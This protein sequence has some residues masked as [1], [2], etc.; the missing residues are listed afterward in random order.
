[1]LARIMLCG[2]GIGHYSPGATS[3]TLPL[4]PC[5]WSRR[6]ATRPS[7]LAWARPGRFHDWPATSRFTDDKCP[8]GKDLR[9]NLLTLG[10]G[11]LGV[12]RHVVR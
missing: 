9:A 10:L 8:M 7:V 3:P 5:R 12:N 2:V 6:L 1:M 11:F 4:A